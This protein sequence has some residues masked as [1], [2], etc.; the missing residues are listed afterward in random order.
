MILRTPEAPPESAAV[1]A[2][3]SGMSIAAA[4]PATA[5]GPDRLYYR[6]SGVLWS[7]PRH[8]FCASVWDSSR[9]KWA[10]FEF[11]SCTRRRLYRWA[12]DDYLYNNQSGGA[13]VRFQ[14]YHGNTIRT[15]SFIGYD[16]QDWDPI[17]FIDPC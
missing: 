1:T 11:Y 6:D 12:G 16:S 13:K 3:D 8:R 2:D 7:C 9:G 10:V 15:I 4:G 5:P 17:W 14:N